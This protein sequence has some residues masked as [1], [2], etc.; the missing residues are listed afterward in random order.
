MTMYWFIKQMLNLRIYLFGPI[1]KYKVGQSV[2]LKS[3]SQL[4]I[5]VEVFSKREMTQPLVRCKW[6][7]RK[8]DS[9]HTNLFLEDTLQHFDWYGH[10]NRVTPDKAKMN[11]HP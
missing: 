11:Q 1:S 7:D 5:V 10:N 4:M 8:S 6:Y 3:G 9:T 2:E